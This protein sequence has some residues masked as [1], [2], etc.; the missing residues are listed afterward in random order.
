MKYKLGTKECFVYGRTRDFCNVIINYKY[1]EFLGLAY[2]IA[3][4]YF[5][6]D[7]KLLIV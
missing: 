4:V 7:E 5:P 1:K 2:L 6:W 3:G